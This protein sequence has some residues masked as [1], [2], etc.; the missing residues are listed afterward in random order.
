[1]AELDSRRG[2]ESEEG[3][4]SKIKLENHSNC[5]VYLK[6]KHEICYSIDRIDHIHVYKSSL[7]SILNN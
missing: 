3:S 5:S 2:D 1:M 7:K 4:H 6:Q